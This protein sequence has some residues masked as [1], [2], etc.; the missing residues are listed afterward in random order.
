MIATRCPDHDALANYLLGKL[1]RDEIDCTSDHIDTCVDCESTALNLE[2]IAD[3]L[4]SQL[5]Q[6]LQEV[7][8]SGEEQLLN[9]LNRMHALQ[10]IVTPEAGESN[11]RSPLLPPGSRLGAYHVLGELG[12]GGMGSV[13]KARHTQ[14]EKIIAL[15]VLRA[16]NKMNFS[17]IYEKS[18]Y[19]QVS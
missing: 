16:S 8:F 5:R 2:R 7:E 17:E 19:S 13:F 12:H 9:V 3:Q 18:Q 1:P 14:L 4:I 10:S 6:P 15:K 11:D